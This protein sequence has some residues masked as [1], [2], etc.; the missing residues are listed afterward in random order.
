[1]SQNKDT[2][3]VRFISAF[4]TFF[5]GEAIGVIANNES[6]EFSILP[7]HNNF[8]SI[9]SAGNVRVLT[10]TEERGIAITGGLIHVFE[11]KVEIFANI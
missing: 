3:L 7:E 6:G 1:M 8:I 4:E 9:L 5:E 10:D 11:N 2:I